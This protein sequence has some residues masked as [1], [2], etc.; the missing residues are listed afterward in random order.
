MTVGSVVPETTGNPG[1]PGRPARDHGGGPSPLTVLRYVVPIL[2]VIGVFVVLTTHAQERLSNTDTYF[3][4]RFGHEFLTGNWSLGDPGSVTTYGTRDWVPTQWL[5]QIVMAQ[6]EE[7]FGLAGVAWLSGLIYVSLALTMWVI[8]RRRANPMIAAAVTVV[9]I[10][11]AA[12]GMSMRPQVLS[13][14]LILVTTE[15]WVATHEDHKVRWWLVPLAWLWA[16]VHGMWPVGIVISVVALI[17]LA[18]DRAVA[19]RVWLRLAVIPVLSIAVTAL[20]PVGPALYSAVLEVNSR[21]QYFSEWQPPDFRD[22]DSIAL[23]VMVGAV[24]VSL[25]R[26][27][28]VVPWTHLFLVLLAGGWGLYTDRTVS[29]AAM[30]LVPLAA[31]ALQGARSA[32]LPLRGA[33]LLAV[34]AGAVTCLAVLAVLVPRTADDPPP[35]PEWYSELEAL[36]AGTAVV[37]DWGEGGFLM[38]RFPDLD[39]VVNG[40]GDIYTDEELAR[41]FRLDRTAPSWVADVKGTDARYAL[42]KTSSQLAYGLKTLEGW[43]ELHRSDEMVFLEA[44]E[45]WPNSTSD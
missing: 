17:G 34:V 12:D 13:Y 36:P 19:P 14:L 10:L 20:T 2:V 3:H 43:D 11:A 44:P 28:T 18:L 16:M 9:A 39:F 38:W 21:G 26:Q 7:W 1:E 37:S 42:L 22:A 15:A 24:L 6:V 30:M 32:R 27:R 5:P 31:I 40:Y 25:L 8:A 35:R 33:E 23:L 41:N 4:L 45:D 29:V